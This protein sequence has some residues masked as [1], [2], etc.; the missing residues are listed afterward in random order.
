LCSSISTIS[1]GLVSKRALHKNIIPIEFGPKVAD[2]KEVEGAMHSHLPATEHFITATD[3]CTLMLYDMRK[4]RSGNNTRS[5]RRNMFPSEIA[6][7]TNW[8]S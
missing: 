5:C 2:G 8:L 1:T 7:Q 3:I 4:W 6:G